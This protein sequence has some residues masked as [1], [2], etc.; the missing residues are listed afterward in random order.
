MSE[1]VAANVI[2]SLA[3]ALA[4]AEQLR[5]P[6]APLTARAPML[7]I[8]DAYRIQRVNVEQRISRGERV[9]GRKIG[10][11]AKVM[12]ELF[13]VH[14]PDYGHLLDTMWLEPGQ[15]LDL[16]ELI[17]PQVE[18]EPAFVLKSPLGGVDLSVADV[19]AA[20]DYLCVSFE[21]IDSRIIDWNIRIQD[22]VADNGSSARVILG[23][24]RIAPNALALDN[25]EAV[26][27]LDGRIVAQGNTSAV[28]GHP[29]NG[30]AWLARNLHSYGS[31]LEAGD[32]VLPG[33]CTR[34]WR[35]AGSKTVTG[36][37]AGMG[38][39]TLDLINSPRVIK[40]TT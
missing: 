33:T 8:D 12:Q 34:S 5:Q 22:T 18:I 4:Q 35:M 23:N 9:I 19:L 15:P 37:I 2:N 40:P 38:G 20:T 21:I 10:L 36:R 3:A 24:E 31:R 27:Q 17:D 39:V 16:G 26:V 28:L 13:G 11:T 29:A 32:I 1:A 30:V 7:S 14:E 6:I 25:L